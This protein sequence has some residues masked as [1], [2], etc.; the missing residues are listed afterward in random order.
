MVSG[1]E[2]G[3]WPMLR[4][5][6]VALAMLPCLITPSLADTPLEL[7]GN[8]GSFPLDTYLSMRDDPT[9]LLTIEAAVT[10]EFTRPQPRGLAPGTLWYRFQVVRPASSTEKWLLSFGEPD[11]DDARLYIST[12]SGRFQEIALGLKTDGH[13]PVPGMRL[14]VAP[15]DLPAD[16]IVT[17]YL[18]LS[19]DRKLRFENATIWRP[20]ALVVA[21]SRETANI[22]VLLGLVLCIAMVSCV[23]GLWLRDGVVL[24]YGAFVATQFCGTLAHSGMLTL[25]FPSA[26]NTLN[27][28]LQSMAHVGSVSI[29]LLMWSLILQLRKH[30]PKIYRAYIALAAFMVLLLP[31]SL[32]SNFHTMADAVYAHDKG[33]RWGS[34]GLQQRQHADGLAVASGCP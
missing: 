8:A 26:N 15:L 3:F 30:F 17:I 24:A 1:Q 11:I 22:G 16:Q 28:I 4:K 7:Q 34:G 27:H 18:R 21:E 2:N 23:V 5:C 20:E 33:S 32:G 31:W 10:T 6:C 29:F 13:G 14:N 19:T 9:G 25:L 12:P